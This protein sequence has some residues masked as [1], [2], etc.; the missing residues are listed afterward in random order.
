MILADLPALLRE[1]SRFA[2]R[3]E[4]VEVIPPRKAAYGEVDPA[5]PAN[6]QAALAKRGVRLHTHQCRALKALR[7][8]KI[9]PGI[10]DAPIRRPVP[11]PG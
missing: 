6:I 9:N 7:Q 8:G 2:P 11:G 10:Y 1:D 3:I 4:H 5:L